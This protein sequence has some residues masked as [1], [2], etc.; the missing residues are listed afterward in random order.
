MFS[1][2]REIFDVLRWLLRTNK[3]SSRF[4]Y[5]AQSR[6]QANRVS[7][8]RPS[9]CRVSFWNTVASPW[10]DSRPLPTVYGAAWPTRPSDR[11]KNQRLDASRKKRDR[12]TEALRRS[13]TRSPIN[14]S[15]SSEIRRD[16]NIEPSFA[17]KRYEFRNN[18]LICIILD[19]VP[20]DISDAR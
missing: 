15:V 7:I 11:W 13:R 3:F 6:C 16:L 2:G 4:P 17:G 10:R 5:G 8:G 9:F 18:S 20:G 1:G 19:L 12:P 14:S